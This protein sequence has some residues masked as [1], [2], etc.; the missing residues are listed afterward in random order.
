MVSPKGELAAFATRPKSKQTEELTYY[1]NQ[2]FDGSRS[3]F[4]VISTRLTP[5]EKLGS[6]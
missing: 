1:K 4:Q 2:L 5:V 3:V 6:F